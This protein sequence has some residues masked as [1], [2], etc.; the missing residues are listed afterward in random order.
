MDVTLQEKARR[1]RMV[2]LDIDGVLSDGTINI[3]STGEL[4]KSFYVR[5]GLGIK[6]LQRAGLR[7]GIITG[8]TSDIVAR[9][10]EELGITDLAQGQRFKTHAWEAMLSAYDLRDDEVAYMGDD[11]PDLPLLMRAGLA[12]TP[13]DG[14]EDLDKIVHWR[15]HYTGG[16]GAV[17][18]FAELIL[19]AQGH[20]DALIHRTYVEG[21]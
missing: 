13:A 3:S 19:R 20:W 15:S 12:A 7:V 17:R 9:R 16:H 1:I 6:M 2:I 5:D 8:R 21:N 11:V 10:A 14:I 4:Y 18:E